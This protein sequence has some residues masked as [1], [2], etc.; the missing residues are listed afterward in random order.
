LVDVQLR[1]SDERLEDMP[2]GM[3][4]DIAEIPRIVVACGREDSKDFVW[5]GNCSA[6][7]ASKLVGIAEVICKSFSLAIHVE[8]ACHS[9]PACP[10]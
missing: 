8:V 6:D 10:P 7:M 1:C 4:V 3:L 9:Y 5:W 2:V